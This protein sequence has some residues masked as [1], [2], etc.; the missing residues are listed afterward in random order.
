MKGT[1]IRRRCAGILPAVIFRTNGHQRER[2]IERAR[3]K[4]MRIELPLRELGSGR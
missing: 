3:S 4:P 1:V 2:E